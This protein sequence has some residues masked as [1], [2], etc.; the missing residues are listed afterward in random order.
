MK[1]LAILRGMH[2]KQW[3]EFLQLDIQRQQQARQPA[4]NQPSFAEYDLS[5]RNMQYVR[6]GLPRETTNR[7][8]FPAE[9]YL[10]QRPHEAF[11]EIQHQ[12]REDF[13]NAYSRY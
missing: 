12:R 7:Y 3:E 4:Y 11:G 13:G 9:N 10:V 8:Q 2:M 5:P 1:K 6:S